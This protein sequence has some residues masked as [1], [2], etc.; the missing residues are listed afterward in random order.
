MAALV[1][2]GGFAKIMSLPPCEYTVEYATVRT[3][4]FSPRS[5]ANYEHWTGTA[6]TKHGRTTYKTTRPVEPGDTLEAKRGCSYMN[7]PF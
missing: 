2:I 1:V 7:Q 4:H 3:V 5:Y 6:D